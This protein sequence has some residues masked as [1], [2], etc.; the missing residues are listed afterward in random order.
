MAAAAILKI[1][2]FGHNS[3]TDCSISA[4]LCT[5]KQNGMPTK[6]TWQKLHIFK[7]QDGERPPFWKSLNDHISVKILSDLTTFGVLQQIL[8]LMRFWKL[9]HL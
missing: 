2:F 3:S 7:I 1:A 8:N 9:V 4:K 6:A 5:K